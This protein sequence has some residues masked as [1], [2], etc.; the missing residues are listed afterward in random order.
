MPP[1]Q[2]AAAFLLGGREPYLYRGVLRC[3]EC[4]CWNTTETQKG[5]NYLQCAKRMKK[6]CSQ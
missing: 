4:G 3:G 5:N 1:L 2:Q 6:D